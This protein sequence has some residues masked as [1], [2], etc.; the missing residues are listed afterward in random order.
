[1]HGT[2]RTGWLVRHGR[3]DEA[4]R[5]LRRLTSP[6][7]AGFDVD[8]TIALMEYTNR[9]EQEM[10][11][12]TSYLDCFK[13]VNLRRTEICCVVW[14]VQAV[15]GLAL[16]GYSTTFYEAAGL[17]TTYAF[18]FTIIQVSVTYIQRHFPALTN[19]SHF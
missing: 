12:G 10:V 9:V 7:V 17:A 16:V 19:R 11:A 13:S 8:A 14:V 3:L 15:C 6:D 4:R 2:D 5:S 1:M 18:D